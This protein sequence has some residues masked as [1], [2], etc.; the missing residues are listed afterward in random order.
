MPAVI[1]NISF[2]NVTAYS[3]VILEKLMPTPLFKILSTFYRT[4]R[5]TTTFKRT[6]L[7]SQSRVRLMQSTSHFLSIHF[8]INLQ[9]ISVLSRGLFLS[10]FLTKLLYIFLIYPLPV[11][12]P[13]YNI[14]IILFHRHYIPSKF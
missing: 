11:P 13:T 7:L 9:Y 1:K 3:E 12:C 5:F 10:D 4:Q 8:N 6:Y 2:V 14:M